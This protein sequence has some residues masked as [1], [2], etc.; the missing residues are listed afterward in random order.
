MADLVPAGAGNAP[1]P[2]GS[3]A[4]S[5]FSPFTDPAGGPVLTRLSAFSAQPAVR[6]TLP[7]FVGLAAIGA[8]L[9]TWNMMAPDPQRVLYTQLGDSE[10]ASVAAALDQAAIPYRIDN[11]TGALSVGES[12]YYR[13]RMLV[14]S[15]GALATPESGTQMLDSLP[16]G[17]SRTL[18]GERLR[19]AREA[20][21]QLTI[22]QIDGVEAVRVHL[23]AGEKSVFV[24]DN[25]P[26]SASVMVRLARGRSLS[27]GQVSAI[28]NLV[29]GSVPGLSSDAVRVV[30]QHGQLLSATSKGA[31]ADRL[32]LQARMETK[33]REQVT[34]LLS[35]MLGE[36]QFSTEIQ[37]DLD[38]AEVT[39]ARESYDKDGVVRSESLQQSQTTGTGAAA[40]VPGVLANTPP[41]PTQA[42]PGPPQGTQGQPG[43]APPANG[44]SSSSRTYELG[45][46]VSVSNV[47]PGNVRRLSV[48]VAISAEA[49]KGASAQQIADLQALV[50]AAVGANPQRGDVVK[51]ITRSFEPVAD[52]AALPF[53]ETSW[54][55]MLVRNGAAVLAVL[56]VLLLGVRPMVKA[57]RGDR[58]KTAKGKKAKKGKK[59]AAADE[60]DDED[61][62][63]DD[64][65]AQGGYERPE[66]PGSNPEEEHVPRAEILNRQITLARGLVAEQPDGAVQAL[67]QMLKPPAS[68]D[69]A[70]AA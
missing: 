35:P 13:A 59:G 54:F 5:V 18:E 34:Q 30:D 27:E 20:D 38:M 1:V 56:L 7:V 42:Q 69:Q 39:S 15:D 24:R 36:G 41:P 25:T 37:V 29:A 65:P 17:A 16:M 60:D 70:K 52:A 8:A 44:E 63:A 2:A 51:V 61:E 50:S 68:E 10:R 23:A 32:D 55:A 47:G 62:D 3:G 22:A 40:G 26:P 49:M 64:A 45:R 9:L 14:A 21:L 33:L 4:G 53:Y 11:A 58:V 46:E 57:V 28:V 12:N 19:A 48:A 6:K 43:Q 67:R 31:D 66:V